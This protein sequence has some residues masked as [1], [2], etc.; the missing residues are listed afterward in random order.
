MKIKYAVL[1]LFAISPIAAQ[2]ACGPLPA[3]PALLAP[4]QITFAQK[5]ALTAQ[6]NSFLQQMEGFENCLSTA[7][8]DLPVP[9]GDGSDEFYSS[10]EYQS[11]QAQFDALDAQI[12]QAEQ[13]EEDTIAQYNQ[14]LDSAVE[15]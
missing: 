1:A 7:V 3:A 6:L 11:Y 10:S 15:E 8:S 9:E 12:N 5:D 4:S 13:Y 14:Q 2:A